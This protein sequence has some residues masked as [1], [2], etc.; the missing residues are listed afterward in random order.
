MQ[1]RNRSKYLNER[2]QLQVHL[3]L[4]LFV[5]AYIMENRYR[6][7]KYVKANVTDLANKKT[8]AGQ[9]DHKIKIKAL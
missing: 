7:N 4:K 1:A 3:F 5:K 2:H 6:Q 9:D 8:L